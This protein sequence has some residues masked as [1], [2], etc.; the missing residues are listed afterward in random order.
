MSEINEISARLTVLET[1]VR[2]LIT[3]LA[4]RADDPPRWIKTR[5][6]LALN[7][8]DADQPSPERTEQMHDALAGLLDQ[9]EHVAREYSYSTKRGTDR[10]LVR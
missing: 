8:L 3:H 7:A 2:Q 6:V 5:K 9:A 10:V 4:V 1:V